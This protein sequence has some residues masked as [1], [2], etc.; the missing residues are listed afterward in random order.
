MKTNRLISIAAV[1]L[2]LSSFSASAQMP[3]PERPEGIPGPEHHQMMLTPRQRAEQRT[4]EMDKVVRLDEKQYKKIYKIF[5]KEEN[6]K[7]AAMG[8]P[9][10]PPPGFMEGGRPPQGG[11]FPGGPGMGSG[12]PG[13]PG[14]GGPP[15]G[16]PFPGGF[17]EPQK[18][19][20]GGKEIDSDEYI[21]AR[22]AK[23]RKILSVEQYDAWRKHHPDPSGVF[24]K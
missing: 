5:L 20:V 21:D 11:G 24:F 6:A 16:M 2:T 15:S 10:G 13:G 23:F 4:N 14:A 19:T 22:E 8:F 1:V 7:E 17:G 9:M 12:F 3:R 18:P